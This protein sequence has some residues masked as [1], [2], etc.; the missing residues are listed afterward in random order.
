[1]QQLLEE[2]F[3]V[4]IS[5]P[6]K[7]GKSH[8][9]KSIL[10]Q[11]ANH[12]DEIHILCSSLDVNEDYD[13][14]RHEN[15]GDKQKFH[16]YPEPDTSHLDVIF[17]RQY[18]QKKR[19][20]EFKRG[21]DLIDFI[22]NHHRQKGKRKSTATNSI[23][24]QKNKR[25]RY[26]ESTDTYA[27]DVE[28]P[29]PNFNREPY[30]F[31]TE[32]IGDNPDTTKDHPKLPKQVLVILDD[33]VDSGVLAQ[34]SVIDKYAMRGRHVG[35][36]AFYASQRIT[37]TSINTRDNSDMIIL[38]SPY[39][40]QEFE[41]LIDKFVPTTSKKFARVQVNKIFDIPH[42]FAVINNMGQ[43]PYEKIG[44]S[45]ADIFLNNV[46]MPVKVIEEKEPKKP[47]LPPKKRGRPP[48]KQVN[49]GEVD[50]TTNVKKSKTPKPK[51]VKK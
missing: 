35:C 17:D 33:V 7:T 37:K 15:Y 40:V 12:F 16:W 51:K 36:S 4:F 2:P 14:F 29:I 19:F 48:K 24:T 8:L 43:K 42:E 34:D 49:M 45:N 41:N 23:Y 47:K 26:N 13:E 5:G 28:T 20:L 27:K 39:S 30:G 3:M 32:P 22:T 46:I 11:H 1:M 31:Y 10:R 38:F 6:R 18:E 21:D 44:Q 9:L 50:T 25:N